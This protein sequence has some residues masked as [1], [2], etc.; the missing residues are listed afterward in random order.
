MMP[1]SPTANPAELLLFAGWD[2]PDDAPAT[3]WLLSAHGVE[4]M[5]DATPGRR[6]GAAMA[7]DVGRGRVVLF[8]GESAAAVLSDTWEWYDG[9]WHAFTPIRSDM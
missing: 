3:T 7:Y 5:T 4:R 8:G 1:I 9:A 2:A 6:R